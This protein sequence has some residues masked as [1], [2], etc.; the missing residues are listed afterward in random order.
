MFK[1]YFKDTLSLNDYLKIMKTAPEG[2]KYC[3]AKC[4]TFLPEEEFYDRKY[5]CKICYNQ[6]IKARKMIEQNQLTYEK[7]LEDPSLV[8]RE[9]VIIPVYRK[10]KTCNEDLTLEKFEAYRKECIECRRNKKKKNYEEEFKK[11]I[12]GLEAAKTDIPTLTNLVRGMSADLLKLAV[13]HYG[14]GMSHEDRVKDKMVVKILDHFKS[15]LNPFICL[16][17][18]GYILDTQF[19]VCDSCKKTKKLTVEEKMIEFEKSLNSVMESLTENKDDYK[20]YN[21]KQL[22]MI[23]TKLEI[24]FMK[25]WD[26]TVIL[27][28]I[29]KDLKKKKEDKENEAKQALVDLGG[30]INLNG[31]LVLSR[32]D[33]YINAT[34][35]C[36]AGGK[37]LD[38]W[39]RLDHTKEFISKYSNSLISEEVK[40]VDTIQG[41][42]GGTWIHPD[43]A[44]QL[45]Q[46]ISID[47]A[48]QVSRWVRELALT[49][50]VEIGKEK[51]SNE[52]IELQKDYKKLEVA[53]RKLLEKKNYYKF[54]KGE[55][56]YIISDMDGKSIKNKAGFEGVDIH[57]RLRQHRTG[58][59]ACRLEYLIYS[60]DSKLVETAILKKFESKKRNFKN[61]EWIFDVEVEHLIK[62]VRTITDVLCIDYEEEKDVAKY[63]QQIQMDFTSA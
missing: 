10:C 45:A 35:M 14:I 37:R 18:C 39:L 54:K 9:E 6:I 55:C 13:K 33:G 61:H 12:P 17:T 21:K 62:S 53:H 34:Q 43:L 49:G 5:N 4:Q 7:F 8:E 50:R 51:P 63:N 31:I 56:F 32:E 36:K 52:L 23:A 60:K 38:N 30:E 28:L 29:L 22:S 59:P 25:S 24:K 44:V 3:N 58:T 57:V 47:F 46:W 42:N 48:I 40:I 26:R 27:D 41:K 11:H 15:L 20:K 2:Q 1:N 16:G 19:T